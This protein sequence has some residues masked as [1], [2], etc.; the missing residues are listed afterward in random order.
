M[1][2]F[3][4]AKHNNVDYEEMSFTN[5]FLGIIF[6]YLVAWANEH[7]LPVIQ[8]SVLGKAKGRISKTHEEGRA[9]D[10]SVRGWPEKLIQEIKNEMNSIY[11]DWGTCRPGGIPKV[12]VYHDAGSGFHIHLQVRRNITLN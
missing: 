9:I 10:I 2:R 6:Y 11:R 8:T 4:T 12:F 7:K 5:P 3:W 1:Q